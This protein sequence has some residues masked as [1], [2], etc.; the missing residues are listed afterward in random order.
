MLFANPFPIR[1]ERVSNGGLE[2]KENSPRRKAFH[3]RNSTDP[4]KLDVNLED[5][6]KTSTSGDKIIT[7]QHEKKISLLNADEPI[8]IQ[9]YY[10]DEDE[11]EEEEDEN[12]AWM[13]I[14]YIYIYI[15]VIL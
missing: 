6:N 8:V 10:G 3:I 9:R 2:L 4:Q 13:Y 15:L 7:S 1:R 11:E 14:I 12:N 5:E